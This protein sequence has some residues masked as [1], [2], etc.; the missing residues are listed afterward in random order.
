MPRAAAGKTGVRGLLQDLL[1]RRVI[2]DFL[3]IVVSPAGRLD[4]EQ[5]L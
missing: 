2:A 5:H 4:A 1:V 3:E